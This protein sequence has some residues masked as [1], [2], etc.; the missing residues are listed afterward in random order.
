MRRLVAAA[1]AI[2]LA[3]A[4]ATVALAASS[5]SVRGAVRIVPITVALALDPPSAAVGAPVKA[6]ATVTN[7]A[8]SGTASFTLELRI[9]ATG[10]LIKGGGVAGAIVL[11]AGK[12]TTV[13][14][15][16]CGSAVGSYVLLARA[17]VVGTHV[18]SPARLLTVTANPRGRCK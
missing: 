8:A 4:P 15:N 1:L 7:V 9:P 5:G 16:V 18:D 17:A 13:T 10:V 12:S 6:R 14:W 3:T 11:K 2:V